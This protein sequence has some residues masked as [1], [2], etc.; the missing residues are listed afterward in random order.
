M[1]VKIVDFGVFD[2]E[3]DSPVVGVGSVK[4]PPTDFRSSAICRPPEDELAE[5]TLCQSHWS[6]AGQGFGGQQR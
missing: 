3:F 5:K 4:C 1:N 2:R 6:E